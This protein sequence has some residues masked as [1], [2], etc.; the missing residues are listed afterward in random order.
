MDL[1]FPNLFKCF[2]AFVFLIFFDVIWFTIS[3][4]LYP[5]FQ[6]LKLQ[7][8]L[9]AYIALAI[10]LSCANTKNVSESAIYG[11][12]VGY[13]SYSVFNGT[14]LTLH[15]EWRRKWYYSIVDLLWGISVC[16]IVSVLIHNS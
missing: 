7:F 13:V 8:A 5:T 10:A 14:E 9:I 2:V 3:K 12:L 1:S 16:T 11:A 15:E 4:P 6:N